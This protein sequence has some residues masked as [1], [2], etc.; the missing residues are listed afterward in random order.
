MSSYASIG[1]RVK[2]QLTGNC[3][4]GKTMKFMKLNYEVLEAICMNVFL[5]QFI[6]VR[7]L[8]KLVINNIIAL[9]SGKVVRSSQGCSKKSSKSDG[10][11]ETNKLKEKSC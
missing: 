11:D 8:L 10:K 6:Q 3:G 4:Q 9:L 7:L 2:L 5:C 1:L